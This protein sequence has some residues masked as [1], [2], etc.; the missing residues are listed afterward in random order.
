MVMSFALALLAS[1]SA[2]PASI[3]YQLFIGTLAGRLPQSFAAGHLA[4]QSFAF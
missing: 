1:T 3:V 2:I 4:D